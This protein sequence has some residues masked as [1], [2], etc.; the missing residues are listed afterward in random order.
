MW[1][2]PP[3]GPLSPLLCLLSLSCLPEVRLFRGQCVT[4]QLPHHPPPSLP[5]LLPQGP[6][7]I[8]GS[9]AINLETEMGLLS[10]LWPLFLS[11]Q[12]VP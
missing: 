8:S 1:P 12:F 7:P 4:C 11:L 3:L 10:I 5:P 6:P 2:E 9:Q